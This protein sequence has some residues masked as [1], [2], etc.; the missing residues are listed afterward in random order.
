MRHSSC[1]GAGRRALGFSKTVAAL[2]VVT[3]GVSLAGCGTG[4]LAV[5]RD[6]W[7]AEETFAQGQAKLTE[8]VLH[9][10]GRI[11][12]QEEEN[13]ALRYQL[14][15]ITSQLTGLDSDFS[16]GLEAI[17]DGQQQLGIELEDQIRTVD[18]GRQE[19]RDDLLARMEIILDEVTAE[20]RRL[21][22]DVEA[23]RTSL[24][25][26]ATGYTH[27]VQRG[28]TLAIIAQQY[29]A[30]IADIVQANDIANPNVISVGQV[31][32]IPGR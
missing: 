28:E 3:L 26:M 24:A 12:A 15:R 20:N 17:R 21:R 30:T 25:S 32:T 1:P 5:K 29:G 22:E 7:E 14:D 23:L 27:E 6:V 13:A 16:R 31:L 4:G 18:S 19:D 2:L 9:M 11:A 8:K 10:E